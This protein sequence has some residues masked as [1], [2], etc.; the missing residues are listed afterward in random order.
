[1]ERISATFIHIYINSIFGEWKE[2]KLKES[3]YTVPDFSQKA[4]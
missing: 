2:G 4:I 3:I 1:M